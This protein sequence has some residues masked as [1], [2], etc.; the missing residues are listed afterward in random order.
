MLANFGATM[1]YGLAFGAGS[2]VS[3]QAV[4]TISVGNSGHQ[5]KLTSHQ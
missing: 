1:A 4:R 2:E 5:E 3:H